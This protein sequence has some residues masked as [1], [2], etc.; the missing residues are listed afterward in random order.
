MRPILSL[1]VVSTLVF[2][3]VAMEKELVSGDHQAKG[4]GILENLDTLPASAG[5]KTYMRDNVHAPQ[6]Y[7]FFCHLVAQEPKMME[8]RFEEVISD[9]VGDGFVGRFCSWGAKTTGLTGLM[10]RGMVDKTETIA[11]V[12]ETIQPTQQSSL[13]ILAIKDAVEGELKLQTSEQE[14]FLSGVGRA[15]IGIVLHFMNGHQKRFNEE[16][17]KIAQMEKGI[18]SVGLSKAI[19]TV[20]NK[21]VEKSEEWKALC[22]RLALAVY[23]QKK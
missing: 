18:A 11:G 21:G 15:A 5:F 4:V 10:V 12:F 19:D 23:A 7:R 14:K 2:P 22:G 20:L 3:V 1:V 17:L 8:R 16:V 6:A 9:S 13:P